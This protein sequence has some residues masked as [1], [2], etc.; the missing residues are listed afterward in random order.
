MVRLSASKIKTLLDCSWRYWT[1]YGP[2]KIPDLG[3]DG[4]ARGSA[5]HDVLECLLRNDRKEYV[6]YINKTKRI[7]SVPFIA[8]FVKKK[9]DFYGV[10]D[11]ENLKMIEEYIVV[12]ISADFYCSGALNVTPELMFE[13][14]NESFWVV[15]YLDK[16]AEYAEKVVLIDYKSQKKKFSGKDLEFSIQA[17]MY[18]MIARIKFPDKELVFE[19]HQLR[20]RASRDKKSPFPIQTVSATDDVLD[21]FKEWLGHISEYV[22]DFDYEKAISNFAKKDLSKQRYCCGGEIG[23]IKKDGSPMHVCSSKYPNIYFALTEDGKT[24][25]T[26][27]KKSDLE[28][29]KKIGQIIEEKV[30]EGCPAWRFLWDKRS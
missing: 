24:L 13:E 19:F 9:A 28:K 14:K 7:S 25:N 15:G 11:K 23:Q 6:E 17:L 22:K 30:Y 18:L 16:I 12:A 5:V 8:R 3:N 26:S 27:Y 21:G 20:D 10:G 29:V 2:D 4:S 1:S